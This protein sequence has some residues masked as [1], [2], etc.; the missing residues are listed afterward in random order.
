MGDAPVLP[1]VA[2][3]SAA[4][5]DDLAGARTE[6]RL[7]ASRLAAEEAALVHAMAHE[8]GD[9]AFREIY[10]RYERRL[11]GLG[12][13]LLRDTGL[14]EELVQ[15]T[16]LRLWRTADRFD[17]RRGSASTFIFAIARRL[18]IDIW[19]R[20]SSRPFLPET[21]G[22]AGGDDDFDRVVLALTVRD[23]LDTLS[24]EHRR[25]LQLAYAGDLT[26]ADI[27]A[28]LGIP[29]GTVKSRSHNAL[30]SFKRAVEERGLSV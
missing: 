26:Q 25:V 4:T 14:A 27:A 16:C 18:A 9:T 5:G 22:E 30:R 7:A 13:N 11:Y 1:G 17:E 24:E 3:L 23:A 2:Q 19:R 20:P 28:R 15:E 29:L 10:R 8:R 12:M 21:E 6:A